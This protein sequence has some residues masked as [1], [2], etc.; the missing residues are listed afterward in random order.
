M[1]TNTSHLLPEIK[2]IRVSA[3]HLAKLAGVRPEDIHY[4]AYKKY[5][6][7]SSNGSKTPFSLRDLHKVSL[8]RDLTRKYRMDALKAS[9]VADELL[10]MYADKP[11]A[12][13]AALGFLEAF[14]RSLTT[15]AKVLVDV[16]F[17]DA[18]VASGLVRSE[19][20][21]VGEMGAENGNEEKETPT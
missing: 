3:I 8:M 2:D 9:T 4:W 19:E 15:L 1:G 13:V 10:R 12:Y 20:L 7:R 18:L 21:P 16:G 5:I 17:V 6:K 11:D 14:D